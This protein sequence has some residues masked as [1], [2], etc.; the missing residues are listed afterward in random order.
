LDT[1]VIQGVVDITNE[2]Y[3]RLGAN[4]Q[5]VNRF[6]S[7]HVFPTDL[8]NNPW[9]CTLLAEPYI[10]QCNFDGAGHMLK[11]VLPQQDRNSIKERAMNWEDYGKLIEFD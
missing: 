5:Y 1:D 6:I 3:N 9:D 2:V 11:K 4:V 10:G 8:P 7:E